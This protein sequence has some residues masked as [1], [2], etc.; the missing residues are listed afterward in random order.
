VGDE[1]AP[2]PVKAVQD[3]RAVG[4]G[5]NEIVIE[6][7]PATTPTTTKGVVPDPAANEVE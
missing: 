7:V 2:L 6:V 4:P 5:T 3:V 1:H